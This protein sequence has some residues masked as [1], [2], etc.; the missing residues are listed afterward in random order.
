MKIEIENYAE[1]SPEE[2]IA[3]LEANYSSVAQIKASADKAASEAA[4]YKKKWREA[5]GAEEAQKQANDEAMATLKARVEELEHERAVTGY[6]NAYLAMG[7]DE[8]LAKNAAEALA[9]GDMDAVFKFQKT[10]NDAREKALRSELLKQTPPPAAGSGNT[11]MTKE[12][13]SKMSLAD[14]AKFAQD[15]P[16]AYNEFYGGN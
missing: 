4:D 12:Q 5:V 14:K 13:F 9:K 7:Y 1:M 10:H 11:T 3:A 8:K 15:N 16:D 6:A 2:K